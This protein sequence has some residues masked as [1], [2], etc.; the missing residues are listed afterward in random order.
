MLVASDV[1]TASRAQISNIAELAT[2]AAQTDWEFP[3][4]CATDDRES[5]SL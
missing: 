2:G 3:T 4:R 5:P 1:P